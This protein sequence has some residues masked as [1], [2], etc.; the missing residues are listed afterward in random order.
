MAC[1]V[2]G[3]KLGVP[4]DPK[5]VELPNALLL[6]PNAFDEPNEGVFVEPKALV[7][8]FVPKPLP[9]A[10]VVFAP[11]EKMGVVFGIN[12]FVVVVVFSNGLIV[13]VVAKI[14]FEVPNP[15]G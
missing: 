13:E 11:K 1:V 6:F 9:G 7:V 15:E 12:E 10:L 3:P 5:V 8:V 2:V 4:V 14:E